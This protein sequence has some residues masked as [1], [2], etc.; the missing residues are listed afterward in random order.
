MHIDIILILGVIL[1][2]LFVLWIMYKRFGRLAI[3]SGGR[4]RADVV[5][6]L[7]KFPRSKAEH[8]AIILLENITGLKF[9]T[10]NPGWLEWRGR[11]LE[12][13]GYNV[14]NKLAF[15][16][17]GPLHYKW[18][19]ENE[20]YRVYIERVVRD[21]VKLAIC[22]QH[23]VSLIVLD[24][25]VPEIHWNKYLK[26]RL[27][28]VGFIENEPYDYMEK[29]IDEAYRNSVIEDEL[30]I[31]EYVESAYNLFSSVV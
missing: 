30:G 10:I 27:Y 17:S 23:G 15:E 19:P 6:D 20:E 13:D 9:P 22:K 14:E 11:T 8:R 16:F 5:K 26:S 7:Q 21:V 25:R 28:D 1:F 12:L 3:K 4:Y 2:V 31:R 29:M 24:M 18:F